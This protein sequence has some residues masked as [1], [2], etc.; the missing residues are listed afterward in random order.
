MG[1][2]PE[3]GLVMVSRQLLAFLL[4]LAAAAS[5]LVSQTE[6]TQPPSETEDAAPAQ[7][8]EEKKTEES[9]ETPVEPPPDAPAK[10]EAGGDDSGAAKK[11]SAKT[12][13]TLKI[14]TDLECFVT[15]G[16]DPAKTLKAGEVL[17]VEVDPGPTRVK[18]T[19][20]KASEAAIVEELILEAGDRER[21]RLKMVKALEELR[22]I[23]ARDRTFRDPES[24]LMWPTH[25]N[26][27]DVDWEAAGLYCE[28]LEH[29]GW[30]DW[31][32]PTLQELDELQ[33]MWSLRSYKTVDPILL[34][35]C[36]PWSSDLID[37]ENAWNFNF[38]YR[39]AFRG[40]L[41]YSNNLRALC[42][43]D[44]SDEIPENTRKNRIAAKKLA[45]QKRK[46]RFRKEAEK[47]AAEAAAAQAAALEAEKDPD[48]GSGEENGL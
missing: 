18:A 20:T 21:I 40:H 35:S 29:G 38:R 1:L 32:L 27:L 3:D 8:E 31:R 19:A 34:T 2:R 15:V 7:S 22:K 17:T 44:G 14:E 48:D 6:P 4:A 12:K 47:A 42:V 10:S 23:Q 9:N 46:E 37:E 24:R 33:A 39:R 11:A 28:N 25:D 30:E 13:A 41:R 5:P 45:K 16:I 36:C 43:R 26:G